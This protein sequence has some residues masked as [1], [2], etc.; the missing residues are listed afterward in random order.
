MH[1]KSETLESFQALDAQ[2]EKNYGIKIKLLHSDNGREYKNKEF[3]KYLA[4]QGIQHHYIVHNTPEHNGIAE[5]LNQTLLEKVR[6]MLYATNLPGSLWGE[7]LKHAIWLK[8]QTSTQA[9]GR[10][11]PFKAFNESKPNLRNLHGWGCKVMIHN[12]SSNKLGA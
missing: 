8:N 7:V 1:K 11:T 2:W 9:L 6:A 4:E 12:D 5:R 3:D 10:K